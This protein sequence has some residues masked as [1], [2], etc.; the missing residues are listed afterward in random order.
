MVRVRTA[1]KRE[2]IVRTA[3]TVFREYGF[4]GASMSEICSRVGGSRATLYGY[5]GSKQRLFLAVAELESH[6]HLHA[7]M[8]VLDGGGANV[9]AGLCRFGERLLTFL[10]QPSALAVRRMVLAESGRG[11]IGR[12]FFV[13]GPQ[14]GLRFIGQY[15]QNAIERGRLR[16]AADPQIMAIH[17]IGLLES[18]LVPRYLFGLESGTPRLAT[19]RQAVS[20]AV[21][22]FLAAYGG[23]NRP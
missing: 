3:A 12:S 19:I 13:Q 14:R 11:E 16:T 22:T 18:E 9:R 10:L 15:L 21:S 20:R 8:L 23:A 6:K 1:A 2:E 4:Q 5:F 7:A 17:F